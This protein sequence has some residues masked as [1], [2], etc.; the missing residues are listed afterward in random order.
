[1]LKGSEVKSSASPGDPGR[2][3]RPHRRE[4]DLPHRA[5]HLGVLERFGAGRPR[6]R[7][8]KLLLHHHEID[9]IRNRVQQERLTPCRCR[10]IS[11]RPGQLELGLGRG[12][13]HYDKRQV[14]AQRDA[15][16]DARRP[17]PATAR[18]NPPDLGGGPPGR[19]RYPG[20][21][22]HLHVSVDGALTRG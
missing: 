21:A 9:E 15:D 2:C 1:M 20:S 22:V 18:A 14:I 7:T 5:A 19:T 3:L 13:K 4:R 16:M 11:R 8:R 17:W 12:R 10:C 6:A